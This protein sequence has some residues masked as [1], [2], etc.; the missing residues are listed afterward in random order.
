VGTASGMFVA[1]MAAGVISPIVDPSSHL[2]APATLERPFDA[3]VGERIARAG[4]PGVRPI[5]AG[6]QLDLTV[7]NEPDLSRAYVVGSD[8][9][10]DL[11]LVG[12]IVADGVTPEALAD[13]VAAALGDGYLRHPRVHVDRRGAAIVGGFVR[14][15]GSF[16]TNGSLTLL[17]ALALAGS[18]TS[19]ASDHVLVHRA[20]GQQLDLSLADVHALQS[21]TL[22]DGDSVFVPEAQFFYML[23]EV[24]NPGTYVLHPG[25]S[26]LQAIALAGGLTP[27]GSDRRVK[28]VRA[29]DGAGHEIDA[30]F[31]D[32][33]VPGDTI[34][35]GRR[36]F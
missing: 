17:E 2:S 8:G 31:S 24:R 4:G 14:L 36:L 7:L 10:L 16:P 28:V 18:P 26:V 29:S 12:R 35:I 5:R 19:A 33:V 23:G 20:N 9:S 21:V 1:L 27:T 22:D 11:P 6:D 25:M 32:I 34:R 30:R 15:P 13:E 3:N